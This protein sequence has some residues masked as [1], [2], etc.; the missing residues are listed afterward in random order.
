MALPE[1]SYIYFVR[2][3]TF[4]TVRSI[5]PGESFTNEADTAKSLNIIQ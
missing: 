1:E 2:S 4:F 3:K 5:K